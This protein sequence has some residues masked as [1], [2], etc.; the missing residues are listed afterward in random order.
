MSEYVEC[1]TKFKD[2]AA[3]IEALIEMGWKKEELEIHDKPAHLYGFQGD[4]REEVANIII[5]KKFVGGSSN[6]IGFKKT[7]DGTYEAIIS[8]F[9]RGSG[10]RHATHTHGYNDNWMKDLK[11]K[12]TEKLYTREARKKGYEVKRKVVGKEVVLTF[13]K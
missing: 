5:R 1:S 3:L 9:D 12:Y 6:D 11:R 10:G 7:E 13:L 4:Q 2:R 8:A